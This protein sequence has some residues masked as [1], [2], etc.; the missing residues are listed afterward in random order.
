ME[1]KV[2]RLLSKALVPI[3]ST[4]LTSEQG[5]KICEYLDKLKSIIRQQ[6]KEVNK[7]GKQRSL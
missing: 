3:H 4:T 5:K 6:V 1:E 2:I 7:N